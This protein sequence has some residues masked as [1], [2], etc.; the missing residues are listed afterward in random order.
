MDVGQP[1]PTPPK[2]EERN[3]ENNNLTSMPIKKMN[4]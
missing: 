3:A 1:P 2:G 4:T